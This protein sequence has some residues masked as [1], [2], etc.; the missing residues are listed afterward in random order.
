M[1]E[2]RAST[3]LD[4]RSPMT[5]VA[6]EI[7]PS[8]E[9]PSLRSKLASHRR[10]DTTCAVQCIMRLPL[11]GRALAILFRVAERFFCQSLPASC[12]AG[13]PRKCNL[14]RTN[15]VRHWLVKGHSWSPTFAA[16][17]LELLRR[18]VSGSL[19]DA[20]PHP[21]RR[22]RSSDRPCECLPPRYGPCLGRQSSRSNHPGYGADWYRSAVICEAVPGVSTAW[23]IRNQ[24]E[25]DLRAKPRRGS[26]SPFAL[27]ATSM[28]RLGRATR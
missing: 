22:E 19:N 5:G 4:Q 23:Y 11:A 13:S 8:S 25:L 15:R 1:K 18:P 6:R 12:F 17:P 2:D 21:P 16:S 9:A 26:P 20:P 24:G 28:M 14:P 27:L 3:S 7:A 10:T